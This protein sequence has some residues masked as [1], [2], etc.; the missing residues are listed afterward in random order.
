MDILF[1]LSH[2]SSARKRVSQLLCRRMTM[3]VGDCLFSV[4]LE[5]EKVRSCGNLPLNCSYGLR[6]T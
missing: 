3:L 4:P 1:I 5:P 2:L 6:M